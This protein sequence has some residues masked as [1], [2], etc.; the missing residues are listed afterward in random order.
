VAETIEELKQKLA[1]AIEANRQDESKR[2]LD[3]R[4]RL[5]N[6]REK[7]MRELAKAKGRLMGL[8]FGIYG[9]PAVTRRNLEA[10]RSFTFTASDPFYEEFEAEYKKAVS[11]LRHPTFAEIDTDYDRKSN[12]LSSFNPDEE[13]ARVLKR[14]RDKYAVEA[15]EAQP[16]EA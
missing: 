10:P 5:D 16:V 2:L 8:A 13:F 7:A 1:V 11:E 12:W 6:E 4:A 9:H 3:M 14:Y 15:R